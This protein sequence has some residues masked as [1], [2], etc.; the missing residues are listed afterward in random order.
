MKKLILI[1]LFLII[2][3]FVSAAIIWQE[4]FDSQ[5]DWNC[6]GST[7]A[8]FTAKEGSGCANNGTYYASMIKSPGRGGSGKAFYSYLSGWST[9]VYYT[10]TYQ[11]S[12]HNQSEIYHRFYIYIDSDVETIT[13]YLNYQ[14]LWRYRT[15][16]SGAGGHEIY[17]NINGSTFANSAFQLQDTVWGTK[18]TLIN[19][20][21]ISRDTWHYFE[22]RMKLGASGTGEVD[23]WFDD[24]STAYYS[25]HAVS[26]ATATSKFDHYGGSLDAA[27]GLGNQGGWE[28]NDGGEYQAAW[29]PVIFDDIVVATTKV[30]EVGGDVTPPELSSATITANGTTLSL[31]FNESV[32]RGVSYENADWDLDCSFSGSGIGITYSS[33]D[34]GTTLTYTI[35]KTIYQYETCNVDFTGDANSIEDVSENENDLGVIVSDP[36]TNNS[37]QPQPETAVFDGLK[38]Q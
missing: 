3:N 18:Y 33:G 37:T 7:P 22:I 24:D 34:P 20:S 35:S 25:N 36:V 30:G 29:E 17:L 8:N 10:L 21:S 4:N 28:L 32:K 1:I 6:T 23:F 38:I 11:F 31:L 15:T 5:A 12:D 26:L 14:K 2:P 27:V 13:G 19:M 9:D 16:D